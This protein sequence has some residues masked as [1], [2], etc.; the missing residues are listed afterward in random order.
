MSVDRKNRDALSAMLMS[1]L[2]RESSQH[3]L[4]S[5]CALRRKQRNQEP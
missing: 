3:D 2:R 1:F 5:T 4:Q